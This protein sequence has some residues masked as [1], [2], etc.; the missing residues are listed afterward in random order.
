MENTPNPSFRRAWT[1][2]MMVFTDWIFP[3][4]AFRQT[5]LGSWAASP[6]TTRPQSAGE[7]VKSRG[8]IQQAWSHEASPSVRPAKQPL[9][10][11]AIFGHV[12]AHITSTHDGS[13]AVAAFRTDM[14]KNRRASSEPETRAPLLPATT[15]AMAQMEL[16]AMH[17]DKIEFGIALIAESILADPGYN[18]GSDLTSV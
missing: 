2:V 18:L 10:H 16:L 7:R 5:G 3:K 15:M 17:P 9:S 4:R 6:I 1:A 13:A 8:M 14:R 12:R 11:P